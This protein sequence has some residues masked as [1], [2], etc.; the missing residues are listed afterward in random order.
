MKEIHIHDIKGFKIGHAQNIEGGTGCTAIICEPGL[1]P[2][3]TSEAADRL[4]GNW[5]FK[6]VE[7]CPADSLRHAQR[8]ECLRA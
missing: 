2:G 3:Q 5:S 7:H 6:A 8:W 4:P 1:L